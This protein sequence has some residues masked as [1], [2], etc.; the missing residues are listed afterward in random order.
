MNEQNNFLI[1]IVLCLGVLLGW[2]FFVVEPRM[3]AE[4]QQLA[5]LAEAEAIDLA[6]QSATGE[7][8]DLSADAMPT[9]RASGVV[10]TAQPRDVAF[11]SSPRVAI[12]TDELQGSIAL[13]GARLDDLILTEYR[14]TTATDAPL[15][16][17]LQRTGETGAWQARHGFVAGAGGNIT[18]PDENSLWV[19]TQGDVLTPATPITLSFTT[20]EGMCCTN[21]SA[22]TRISCSPLSN[23]STISQPMQSP[24]IHSVRLSAPACR[25]PAACSFCT[26]G[27]WASSA[28]PACKSSTMMTCWKTGR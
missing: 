4:R 19:L 12:R 11:A 18:L 7:A 5:L 27:H 26:K 3:E 21:A 10:P 8:A 28:K 15:Q 22:L 25:K 2:Q 17:L 20:V 24:S 14:E 16:R 9:P 23:R 6:T 1:A 13:M